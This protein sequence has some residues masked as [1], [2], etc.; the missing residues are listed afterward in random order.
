M[1][2]DVPFGDV[3]LEH[4][5]SLLTESL[6]EREVAHVLEYGRA[7]LAGTAECADGRR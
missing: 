5:L 7:R 3:D 1:T 2:W 4:V 6:T